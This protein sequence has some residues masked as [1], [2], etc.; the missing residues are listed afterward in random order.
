[1][2]SE[3]PNVSSDLIWEITRSQNAFLVKRKTNGSPQFSRD[4]LNL[5]NQHSRKYAGFVNNKPTDKGGV[6]LLSKTSGNAQRPAQNVQTVTWGPNASNRKI[7]KSVANKTAKTGYRA[8]LREAAVARA[9]AIRQSQRPKKN[10][11][12]PKLRGAKA[13]QAAQKASS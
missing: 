2:A 5:V 11:P 7:Y 4:P 6:V 12:E 3:R 8:D 13:R 1:M 10:A 9:S